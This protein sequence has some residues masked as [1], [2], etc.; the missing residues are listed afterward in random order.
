[1]AD[2]YITATYVKSFVGTGLY[3]ALDGVT[4]F[5]WTQQIETATGL[6]QS[7][8]RNSGYETPSTT[9]DQTVMAATMGVVWQNASALPEKA[10]PLPEDWEN[11]DLNIARQRIL[12]GDETLTLSL[13]KV[14]AVGGWKW[15]ENRTGIEDSR[16]QRSSRKELENW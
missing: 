5:S 2:A 12:S 7:A 9:T 3:N 15:S 16:T 4:G 14:S 10:I 1:M 13:D 11:N 8:L 6:V